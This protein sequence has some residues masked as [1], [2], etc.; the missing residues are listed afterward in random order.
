MNKNNVWYVAFATTVIAG[1]KRFI[2]KPG[3]SGDGETE[4]NKRKDDFLKNIRL[5]IKA[6]GGCTEEE[7]KAAITHMDFHCFANLNS[8]P[9]EDEILKI[10]NEAK[11][12]THLSVKDI[13]NFGVNLKEFFVV[14]EEFY[15]DIHKTVSTLK[16]EC[17]EQ[18]KVIEDNKVAILNAIRTKD[19]APENFKEVMD[20]IENEAKPH[21]SSDERIARDFISYLRKLFANNPATSQLPSSV[22]PKDFL[23]THFSTV[24]KL[25]VT[26]IKGKFYLSCKKLPWKN[27][28]VIAPSKK[29]PGACRAQ[30][31]KDYNLS[32]T[33]L[34]I[35]YQTACLDFESPTTENLFAEFIEDPKPYCVKYKK[36]A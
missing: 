36:A 16:A 7:I 11:K 33:H 12:F 28:V 26:L 14:K 2:I 15:N 34:K 35:L 30:A 1:L 21:L 4:A 31:A 8:D 20:K 25:V 18:Y 10:M 23:L 13:D 24:E 32:W 27:R 22:I 6:W 5:Q 17:L 3:Y 29:T 9:V 19:S